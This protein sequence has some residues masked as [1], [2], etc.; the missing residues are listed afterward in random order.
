MI[1]RTT[2]IA[3]AAL[4]TTAI[5]WVGCDGDGDSQTPTTPQTDDAQT[6]GPLPTPVGT[7]PGGAAARTIDLAT[8]SSL[9]VVYAVGQG[10]LQ[11][12]QP[13][14]AAGDFNDDDIDD[15][16]IGA[17]FADG[18]GDREDS[19]AAYIVLGSRSPPDSV[20][21]AA[22]EQ[23]VTVLGARPG[24]NLGFSAVAADLNGDGIVDAVVGAPFAGPLDQP[25]SRLGRVYVIFGRPDLPV[26]IDLARDRA[27][28]TLTGA[29]S[30]SFFG[31]SLAAGDVNGDGTADLIVGATFDSY[32]PSE[33]AFVRGGAVYVFFGRERWPQALTAGDSDVAVYGAD[34]FDELGDFV[35]SGDVNGDGIDDIIATAEAAD[36][37]DNAR[38]TAAEVHVLF[39]GTGVKGTY[40]IARGQQDLTVYGAHERDTLG[41][42]LASG[43]LDDDGIDELIM[44]ARLAS[45]FSGADDRSGR[46]YVLYGR[47]DPHA[48][49]DLADPPESVATIYGQSHS[50]FLGSSET[51]A[52]LDEDGRKELIMGS[53]FADA[54]SRADSG[55]VYIV[56]GPAAGGLVSVAGEALSTVVYGSAA[57]DRLGTNVTTADFDGDGRLELIVVAEGAAGPDEGRPAAGRVYVIAP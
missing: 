6:P 15:I 56:E 43:D 31:D 23:E 9:T 2:L 38:P 46:V 47:R 1:L 44:G 30:D 11:S 40:E 57:G 54:P 49:V 19:G 10:D 8:A 13:G 33:G 25:T 41:F 21:L 35:T 5:L 37:P 32:A 16:L 52:D 53:G 34:E 48:E 26:G 28:I 22:D 29:R 18:P 51:V 50:D 55:A 36:G 45:A 12:D 14:L 39:G 20:D 7:A 4:L 42:S 24:D 3:F 27:D 17:R